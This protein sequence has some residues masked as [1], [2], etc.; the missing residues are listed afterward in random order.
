[1]ATPHPLAGELPSRG[2]RQV[3]KERIHAWIRDQRLSPG[4]RLLSQNDLAQM[5]GATPLTIYRAM[6]ELS[7]Q[8]VIH[9]RK[10]VGTFV[11]PAHQAV[12]TGEVCLVLP[13][14]D[15]DRPEVNPEY[16]PYVQTL[17][18]AFIEA[19]RQGWSF[20]TRVFNPEQDSPSTIASSFARFDVV[21]FHFANPPV[22]L[23][24]HLIQRRIT[25]VIKLGLPHDELACL[26]VDHDRVEGARRAVGHMLS[27]GYRRIGF[28]GHREY[29][30]QMS[31]DG[32]S[33]ALQD[34]G[35]SP[36]PSWSA[37]VGDNRA[38]G[39]R[40]AS[41]LL[42]ANSDL[43]ALFVDAD[44]RALGVLDAL[45]LRGIHV[46]EDMAVMGYDGLDLAVHH[47]PHLTS[48]EIPY[49]QII[50]GALDEAARCES[51]LM[52]RKHLNF[53]GSVVPG[54]TVGRRV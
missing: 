16:W 30:G 54:L 12:R 52:P 46:P 22:A 53:V 44:L 13:A 42:A 38:E 20:S 48:L 2:K 27:R 39:A 35:I 18:R 29:W 49:R 47:P 21:F 5:T 32:Y 11:G 41:A 45:T 17:F 37:R 7:D 24:K 43:D 3:I 14:Q 1:M 19:T 51:K 31:F 36:Q 28:V 8:G 9:R 34:A 40:G 25:R 10:G 23:M 50:A 26:T 15:L 33:Q 6:Q 4:D